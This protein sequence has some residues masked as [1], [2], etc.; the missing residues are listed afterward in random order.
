MNVQLGIDILLMSYEFFFL[1]LSTYEG[2]K[3]FYLQ[4]NLLM[5]LILFGITLPY[6]KKVIYALPLLYGIGSKCAQRICRILGLIPQLKIKDLTEMQKFELA[7][8][9]KEHFLVEGNLEE[10]LKIDI[11]HYQHNGSRHGY[12]LRNGLPSR[13]QRTRSNAKTAR[14]LNSSQTLKD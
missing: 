13:G 6:T 9:V 1:S 5:N 14:R 3:P 8:K 2:I 7:K 10:Q 11:Q 4:L 12:R